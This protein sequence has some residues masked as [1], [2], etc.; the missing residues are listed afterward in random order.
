ML[1]FTEFY[2]WREGIERIVSHDVAE[3]V[4]SY[5]C[6]RSPNFYRD[7]SKHYDRAYSA[8]IKA[9]WDMPQNDLAEYARA[10]RQAACNAC[11]IDIT[12]DR[13]HMVKIGEGYDQFYWPIASGAGPKF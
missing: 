4:A 11:G 13:V 1:V 5:L 6:E 12:I 3:T 8:A 7:Y 2:H 10:A 9:V